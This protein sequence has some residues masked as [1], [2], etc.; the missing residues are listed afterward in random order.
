MNPPRQPRPATSG[1]FCRPR[2]CELIH[3]ICLTRC[4]VASYLAN[5][6]MT[7]ENRPEVRFRSQ[8][9]G[10]NLRNRPEVDQGRQLRP[11]RSR[12]NACELAASG[13]RQTGRGR[14]N[15]PE[16]DRQRRPRAHPL[17]PCSP[18]APKQG[19]PGEC[20]LSR[21]LRLAQCREV[22]KKPSVVLMR[23][24]SGPNP[25]CAT[26]KPISKP[27]SVAQ[28]CLDAQ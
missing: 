25:A 5:A 13:S 28:F 22:D 21:A 3:G 17:S 8:N 16:A 4:F 2:N 7:R 6:K 15:H 20:D 18:G 9:E 14:C 23:H 27:A 1:R 10:K 19:T 12:H 26:A 11:G 24:E